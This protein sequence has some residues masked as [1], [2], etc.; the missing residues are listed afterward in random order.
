MLPSE[1]LSVVAEVAAAE[2]E[3]L[4]FSFFCFFLR[5]MMGAISTSGSGTGWAAMTAVSDLVACLR[6]LRC[7]LLVV[8]RTAADPTREGGGELVRDAEMDAETTDA[9]SEITSLAGVPGRLE[10]S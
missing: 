5:P 9:L 2:V 1:R 4:G 7:W 3:V 10:D 8:L 6:C